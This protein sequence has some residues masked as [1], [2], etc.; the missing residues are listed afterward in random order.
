MN[1]GDE[2]RCEDCK[3]MKLKD[4]DALLEL[5]DGCEGLHVPV[6]VVIQNIKDMPTIDAVPV[7]RCVNCKHCDNDIIV[8]RLKNGTEKRINIC[9]KHNST[10]ADDYFCADGVR[11]EHGNE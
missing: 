2:K 6:E 3:L 5:Y 4:A 9:L 7:V 11:K 1:D 10:V 8:Q